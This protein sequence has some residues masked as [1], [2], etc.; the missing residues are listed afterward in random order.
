MRIIRDYPAWEERSKVPGVLTCSW[1]PL[2]PL[3]IA[4]WPAH[5]LQLHTKCQQ[6]SVGC[7]L[8]KKMSTTAPKRY[9][10]VRTFLSPCGIQ[11][12]LDHAAGKVGEPQFRWRGK[13]EGTRHSEHARTQTQPFFIF[14]EGTD[15]P[16]LRQ[17]TPAA[18]LSDLRPTHTH[19][20]GMGKMVWG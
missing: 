1:A 15:C 2:L 16:I 19:A 12:C 17:H 4:F 7:D 10:P 3:L 13:K 9:L 18:L 8:L 20:L 6:A 5:S 11:A 14:V